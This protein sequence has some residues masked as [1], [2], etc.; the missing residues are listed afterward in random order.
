MSLVIVVAKFTQK[1][2]LGIAYT[3]VSARLPAV[4]HEL[5]LRTDLP[6]SQAGRAGAGAAESLCQIHVSIALTRNHYQVDPL[7]P[8][9]PPDPVAWALWGQ[10]KQLSGPKVLWPLGEQGLWLTPAPLS[11]PCHTHSLPKAWH[12]G[13]P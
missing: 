12:V 13:R 4:G 7:V 2:F 6:G 9:C 8:T 1:Y 11:P 3:L 10:G 5:K